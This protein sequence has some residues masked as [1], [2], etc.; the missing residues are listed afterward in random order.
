MGLSE[1]FGLNGINKAEK[2]SRKRDSLRQLF[3]ASLLLHPSWIFC[4]EESK[5]LIFFLSCDIIVIKRFASNQLSPVRNVVWSLLEDL[6]K[7]LRIRAIQTSLMVV[8][9][10]GPLPSDQWGQEHSG[11]TLESPREL[12]KHRFQGPNPLRISRWDLGR[13]ICEAP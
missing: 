5:H 8:P 6:E 13:D 9:S 4:G 10:I 1:D 2:G 7:E 3:K 12:K 11:C